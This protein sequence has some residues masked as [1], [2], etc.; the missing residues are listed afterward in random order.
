[1]CFLASEWLQACKNGALHEGRRAGGQEGDRCYTPS[2]EE[3][4]GAR[5]D[6]H[7][8][9]IHTHTT[10]ETKSHSPSP[11]SPLPA[12]CIPSSPLNP[13]SSYLTFPG[14]YK[15]AV[16]SKR[17]HTP[18]VVRAVPTKVR[19]LSFSAWRRSA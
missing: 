6:S 4:P 9:H 18:V 12:A 16:P 15:P 13:Y 3:G 17:R 14:L 19:D 8:T 7:F 5:W 11:K 10:S 1:M 2:S